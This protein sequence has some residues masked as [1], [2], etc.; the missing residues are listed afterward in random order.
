MRVWAVWPFV[1]NKRNWIRLSLEAALALFFLVGLIQIKLMND[2]QSGDI[3]QMDGTIKLFHGLG[4]FGFVLIFYFNL[5]FVIII[6][7][8]LCVGCRESNRRKM[9][10]ARTKYYFDKIQDY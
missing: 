1:S 5:M 3:N 4:W 10:H 6:S 2:I 9:D 8:D 7:Y